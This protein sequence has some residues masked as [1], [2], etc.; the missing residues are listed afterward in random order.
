MEYF[1]M[2]VVVVKIQELKAHPNASKLAICQVNDG[3]Q[4]YQ[5]VCGAKNATEGLVTILAK[6]GATLPTGVKIKAAELRGV[7]SHGML[8]SPKDLG[9]SLE[10]GIV[11]LPPGTE[12]GQDF[13]KLS[14]DE[15]SSTPWYQYQ[16][17]ENMWKKND[18]EQ[19]VIQRGN[20]TAPEQAILISQTYFHD[21]EYRYRNFNF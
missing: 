17:V 4:S 12:L 1:A 3:S 6:E 16:W 21:G 18:Q 13:E 15:L 10:T 19:I 5:V 11:D 2:S 8:C 14:Q 20:E 9:V 7:E